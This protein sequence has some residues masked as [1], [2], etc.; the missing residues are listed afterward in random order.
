MPQVRLALSHTSAWC[1]DECTPGF[2]PTVSLM[3]APQRGHRP[4]LQNTQKLPSRGIQVISLSAPRF[5]SVLFGAAKC[6]RV[7]GLNLDRFHWH[8]RDVGL[9]SLGFNLASRPGLRFACGGRSEVHFVLAVG[10]R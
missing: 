1:L 5:T 6:F 10:L 3:P 8:F 4:T 7:T 9:H 2:S